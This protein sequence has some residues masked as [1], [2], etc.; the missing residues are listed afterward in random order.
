V[1]VI[2]FRS[3]TV[4]HPTPAMR[5]AMAKAAVGDDVYGEDPTVNELEARAAFRLG[6]EAGLFVA[7]GTMGNLV[8]ILAHAGRGDEAIGGA[9]GHWFRWEAGAMAALGGV[10]PCPLPT[11]RYGRMDPEAVA[12]VF[13][14]DDPHL[15][16]TR[17]ILLE[18]TYGSRSGYPLREEYLASITA[19][20]AKRFLPVHMDGARLFNAAVALNVDAWRLARHADSVT[21]CLSKGLSAPVGSVLCGSAAFVRR[22][23]R[24]RKLVGGGMRQAGILAAAGL[25]ALEQMVDR[26]AEDHA[27]A[28]K[29]AAGLARIAG[30]I[31]DPAAVHTNI[32][33]FDLAPEVPLSPADVSRRLREEFGILVSPEGRPRT[34]R[35]VT[36]RQ[37]GV[38]EVGL[39][40]EAVASVLASAAP[41]RG[42]A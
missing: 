25:V 3:D 13:R 2:D 40:V 7:S 15:P 10:V 11:D 14:P 29:L 42:D 21:F 39:L 23:R 26:L 4:T 18:N 12:G 6:K 27:N 34:V 17:L 31:L 30:V 16:T 9:D 24:V 5:E 41:R 37:V 33:M 36:H 28:A 1:D 32:V 35:A 8:A 22:A 20:A 38:K 19:V